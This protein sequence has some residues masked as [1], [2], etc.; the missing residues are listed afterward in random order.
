[1]QAFN[2]ESVE[3]VRCE[4][5]SEKERTRRKNVYNYDNENAV[6]F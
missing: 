3:R 4:H 6:K 5:E 1:M 2:T